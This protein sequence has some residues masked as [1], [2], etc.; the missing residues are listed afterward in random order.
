[1]YKR[2]VVRNSKTRGVDITIDLL[3]LCGDAYETI[4]QLVPI[5]LKTE[6]PCIQI[7]LVIELDG[8]ETIFLRIVLRTQQPILLRRHLCI[9][10]AGIFSGFL[11]G[12]LEVEVHQMLIA[13]EHL[14]A[15]LLLI[16]PTPRKGHLSRKLSTAF[17]YHL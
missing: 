9:E 16:Q 2:L 3:V 10:G 6:A 12:M 1:M 8:V 17:S 4:S 15:E 13:S 14:V 7:H 11:P 5:D